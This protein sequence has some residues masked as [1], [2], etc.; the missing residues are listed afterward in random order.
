MRQPARH[1]L[2]RWSNSGAIDQNVQPARRRFYGSK[3]I[4]NAIGITN[5]NP[6]KGTTNSFCMYLCGFKVG[7]KQR[8]I[9]PKSCQTLGNSRPLARCTPRDD[10]RF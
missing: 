6:L 5:I 9:D 4:C 8:Y 7:I 1:S 2:C 3:A 10:R